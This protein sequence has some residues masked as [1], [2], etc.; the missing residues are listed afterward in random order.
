M[1][2]E[3]RDKILVSEF[4]CSQCGID[5]SGLSRLWLNATQSTIEA[6]I[7]QTIKD[8]YYTNVYPYL[9][10]DFPPKHKYVDIFF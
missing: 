4:I 7:V 9:C 3:A 8:Q 1:N 6:E 2:A 10:V 5:Q